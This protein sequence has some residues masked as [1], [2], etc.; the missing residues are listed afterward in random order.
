MKT[1]TEFSGIVL[2]EAARIVSASSAARAR[3]GAAERGRGF[4]GG[5]AGRGGEAATEAAGETTEA[6]ASEATEATPAKRPKLRP[7]KRPKRSGEAT[8]A[9][10]AKRPKRAQRSDR[11]CLR[12]NDGSGA[13]G[14]GCRRRGRGRSV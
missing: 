6:A 5:D 4:P 10:A 12:R 9:A 14:V 2:R 3:R 7:A 1:I 8:E 11:R 13:R